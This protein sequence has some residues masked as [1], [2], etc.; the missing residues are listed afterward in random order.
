MRSQLLML[1]LAVLLCV[2]TGCS[3]PEK[4]KD[5]KD[6]KKSGLEETIDYATGK[7]PLDAGQQ[8][9]A[10]LIQSAITTAVNYYE[11]MEGKRPNNLQEMVDA[12]CLRK[13]YLKDEWG[14]AL[15]SSRQG[16]KLVVRGM[17]ADKIPN[18]PDDWVEEY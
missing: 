4:K 16:D 15:I 2:V 6:K 1:I 14:R 9:K 18:T 7:T 10:R 3:G 5:K 12:D 11:A 8:A 17:G 13:E